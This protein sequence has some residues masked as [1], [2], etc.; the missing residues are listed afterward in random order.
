MNKTI[1]QLTK[2]LSKNGLLT[3][4][5]F[6]EWLSKI[7]LNFAEDYLEFMKARNGGEGPV[8]ENGY[9]RFWPLEELIELN[10]MYAVN[11][12]APELFL[13]GTDGGGTAFGIRKA[14]GV[15][16]DT[17]LVGMSDEEAIVRGE[18][19]ME[20]LLAISE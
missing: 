17:D 6:S 18:S 7:N 12:F 9:A 3:E 11:K 13:I 2:H 1:E 14:S 16:I 19:F 20:L 10:E 15:F 4:S 8:G 5:Q